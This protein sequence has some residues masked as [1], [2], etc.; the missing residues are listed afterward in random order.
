MD[1]A[2]TPGA[3]ATIADSPEGLEVIVPAPRV[4]PLV[5]F[6][7]FWLA[8]WL[9]GEAFA[10][11]QLL[12][13]APLPVR[14]FLAVWLAGWTLGGA[15]AL[16]V[17]VWMLVGHE[18]VRLRPDALVIQWEAFGLGPRRSYAL[19]RI[20]DLRAPELP[21]LPVLRP[22]RGDGVP[23]AGKARTALRLVGVGGPGIVFRYDGRPVRFGVA[24][25]PL[26]ARH[27]VTQLRGR[28][29]FPSV[30]GA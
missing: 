5:V 28:H 29:P 11:R 30:I 23:A 6:L 18:R 2:G 7:G 13:P 17:V 1:L 16:G 14:L 10:L 27:V 26:E 24:L 19:D 4:W 25:D 15:G 20:Q 12:G 3:R 8:G 21:A 22:P 9:T